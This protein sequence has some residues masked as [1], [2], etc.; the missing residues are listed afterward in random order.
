MYSMRF[1]GHDLP[2][3][4]QGRG[5]AT[6]KAGG[7]DEDPAVDSEGVGIAQSRHQP[8]PGPAWSIVL[9]QAAARLGTPPAGHD[10]SNPCHARDLT[11][12]G[13]RQHYMEARWN[14]GAAC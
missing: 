11:V 12:P 6:R 14:S 5:V 13:V 9:Q 7:G 3:G 4:G 8:G 2:V 10:A 1:V